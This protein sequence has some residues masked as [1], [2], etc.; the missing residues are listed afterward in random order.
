[1]G[2]EGVSVRFAAPSDGAA[3]AELV[4][5]L[6]DH[7][8]D[9][10]AY[11][12]RERFLA[13]AFGPEPQFAVLVAERAGELVGYALFFDCYEPAFAARGVY[14]SDLFVSARARRGGV[15]RALIAA[16]ARDA[17]RR[18]RTFVWWVARGDDARAFY[19]TLTD[20]EQAASAHAI[21]FE[22]FERLAA[23]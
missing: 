17:K 9:D 14:L 10:R 12:D 18:E 1:M 4:L 15:G 13:D 11:F 20:V 5:G 8:G 7:L 2:D 23:E 6:M 22:T 16:V 3:L 19:R 21:T